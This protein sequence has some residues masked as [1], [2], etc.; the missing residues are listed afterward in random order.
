MTD[1]KKKWII[2]TNVVV[3]WLMANQITEF[4]TNKFGLSNEFLSTY[5]NR[6]QPSIDFI[7]KVLEM[8]KGKYDFLMVELSLNEIFSGVRDEVRSILLFSKGVPL[9]RW[10]STRETKAAR[11]PEGL[12]RNIYE[13]TS[14][15]FDALFGTNR[16]EI[17]PATSPSDEETYLEVYSSLVFL[18]PELRTQDAILITTGIFEKAHYFVSMDN[19]LISLGKDKS[20]IKQY[21]LEVMHPTKALQTLAR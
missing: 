20:F 10:A 9:S 1:A 15:G 17:I 14:K 8:S 18:Y 21:D 11:F 13:L 2:D 7:N 4:C 12:S 5:K 19:A 3:H 6:Y 16:V